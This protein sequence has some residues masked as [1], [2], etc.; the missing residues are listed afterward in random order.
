[1]FHKYITEHVA[2][3][4][5]GTGSQNTPFAPIRC[6]LRIEMTRKVRPS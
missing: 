3:D 4:K 2:R 5:I 6:E 1:M